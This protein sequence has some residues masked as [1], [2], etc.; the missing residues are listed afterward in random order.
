MAAAAASGLSRCDHHREATELPNSSWTTTLP[1]RPNV[2]APQPT[3]VDGPLYPKGTRCSNMLLLPPPDSG[4]PHR[5][6]Q[7]P[8]WMSDMDT[9]HW[10]LTLLP[11]QPDSC[12][13]CRTKT[14][15]AGHLL[16]PPL[17]LD[18]YAA[19]ATLSTAT[20]LPTTAGCPQLHRPPPDPRP[21]LNS[22]S[23]KPFVLRPKE[24]HDA[25]TATRSRHSMMLPLQRLNPK[26]AAVPQKTTGAGRLG[27]LHHRHLT[28]VHH[29]PPDFH[30]PGPATSPSGPLRIVALAQGTHPRK[31]S[32][33]LK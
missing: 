14:L 13:H 17:L 29:M 23:L 16:W 22:G 3:P 18:S 10:V 25:A 8:T 11:L 9:P 31:T 24:L 20:E 12:Q 19:P 4:A 1:P 2:N 15:I 27:I 21:T 30:P 6:H 28:S 7:T 32:E 33:Y 26:A 5:C